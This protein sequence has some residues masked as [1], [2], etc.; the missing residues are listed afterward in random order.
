MK[1]KTEADYQEWI[2]KTLSTLP[3]AKREAF[4]TFTSGEEGFKLFGDYQRERDYYTK[5]NEVSEEKQTIEQ[6]KAELERTQKEFEDNL[7]SARHW[8]ATET[9]R[10]KNERAAMQDELTSL[11]EKLREYGLEDE[12]PSTT[13]VQ[14]SSDVELREQLA[15]LQQR[16]LFMDQA[17]PKVLADAI[18][19]TKRAVKDGF[20]FDSANLL[21]HLSQRGGD[22]PSAYDALTAEQRQRRAD[23]QR[24]KEIDAAREEGRRSALST[25][26]SPDGIRPGGPS[27]SDFLAGMNSKLSREQRID[28]AVQSYHQTVSGS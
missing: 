1:K 28:A 21:N 12:A 27:V 4:R 24:K 25:A 6:R 2:E 7:K 23:E 14:R 17:V 19:V 22:L 16:V 5:L 9:S 15:Q 20:E 10:F 3:E 26:T 8:Y 13:K 11:R 18:E